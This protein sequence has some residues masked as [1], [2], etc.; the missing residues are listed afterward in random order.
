MR[1]T[2]R[3]VSQ[4]SELGPLPHLRSNRTALTVLYMTKKLALLFGAVFVLVG[5]LGFI[6]AAAPDEHLLGIFHVNA[7]HNAVHL[8]T[9]IV[10]ILCG[11]ASEYAAILFFRIFGVVY[12]LVAVL[13]LISGDQPIL[14]IISNNMAD[15]WLHIAIA[16]VSLL[17]GFGARRRVMVQTPIP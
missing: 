9:G 7:A 1:R 5:I 16:A 10:A 15:V 8:L 2:D 14:G 6:P 4:R 3:P 17:I 11:M 12:G 13:G